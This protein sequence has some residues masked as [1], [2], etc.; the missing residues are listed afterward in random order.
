MPKFGLAVDTDNVT[1]TPR[2]YE[3]FYY[4]YDKDF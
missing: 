3:K 4:S 2:E 1:D